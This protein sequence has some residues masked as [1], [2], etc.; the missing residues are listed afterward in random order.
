MAREEGKRIRNSLSEPEIV[1]KSRCL[2]YVRTLET[3]GRMARLCK[4]KR[5]SACV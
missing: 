2:G 5:G 1:E 4:K 3:S